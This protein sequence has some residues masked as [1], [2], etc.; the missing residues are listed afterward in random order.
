MP[1]L[2][3]QTLKDRYR[4]IEFL[5]QSGIT[6]VYKVWDQDR[7]VY[8]VLRSPRDD[9]VFEMFV[10]AE[11]FMDSLQKEAIDLEKLQHPNIVSFYGIETADQ[12]AIPL[13]EGE[14]FTLME[15]IEGSSLREEIQQS[16]PG[17]L[18]NRRIQKITANICSALQYAHKNGFVHGEINPGNVTLDKMGNAYLSGFDASRVWNKFDLDPEY[19]GNLDVENPAYMSPE[20]LCGK[21]PLP[22]SDVYSLGIL[23]FEMLTGGEK[24]F[25]GEHAGKNGTLIGKIAWEHLYLDAPPISSINPNVFTSAD[26]IIARCLAKDPADRYADAWQIYRE[27]SAGIQDSEKGRS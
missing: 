10:Y 3:G 11:T 16:G 12:K 15:Y 23:L 4:V 26:R 8:L 1:S 2:V 13:M 25:T 5:G 17:G 22:Q 7:L 18:S 24:P 6:Q 9:L 19:D 14:V 20:L 21:D 27:I